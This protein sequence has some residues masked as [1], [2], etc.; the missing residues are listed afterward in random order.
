MSEM[1]SGP[2][3]SKKPPQSSFGTRLRGYFF[4]SVL[5]TAPIAITF[6]VAGLLISLVPRNYNPETYLPFFVPGIGLIAMVVV[7]TLVGMLAA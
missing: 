6:Y 5:V 1:H 7:L 2:E 4:A 3:A